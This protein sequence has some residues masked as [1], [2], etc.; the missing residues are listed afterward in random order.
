MAKLKIKNLKQVKSNIRKSIIRAARSKEIKQGVADTVVDQIRKEAINVRSS[1]TKA[2]RK[3]LER[4]N[5][6][7]PDYDRDKINVTFTGEQLDDLKKNP[8]IDT[9]DGK[10]EYTIQHS[11]KG[12]HKK[13]KKPN[14]RLV[15]G[16]A[17]TYEE[18]RGYLKKLGYDYLTFSS[19]SKKR[20]IK[21][22]RDN[23]FKNLK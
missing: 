11:K 16:S 7:H 4:G 17:K 2:W 12:K 19:K 5:Q 20:V 14:G 6:T 9:T 22:I 15:K 3:Y 10:I 23:I 8:L 1:A 13:Y 21:F 18:I